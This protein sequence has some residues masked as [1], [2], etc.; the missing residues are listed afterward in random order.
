MP[1]I[2]QAV[3]PVEEQ[4]AGVLR[5][6]SLTI[7]A[8]LQW[9][10]VNGMSVRIGAQE[11]KAIGEAF[12][13]GQL[14]RVVIGIAAGRGDGI[15]DHTG[16]NAVEWIPRRNRAGA[17]NGLIVVVL[18][19]QLAAEISQ[20]KRLQHNVRGLQLVFHTEV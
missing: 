16:G 9:N 18:D 13:G 10:V 15:P 19:V 14:Q 20:I 6:R 1:D 4:V 8:L 3:A 7:S 11:T 5:D 17:G 12:L 2:E